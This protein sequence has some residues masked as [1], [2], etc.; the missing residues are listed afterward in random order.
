MKH[1]KLYE[2]FR[3]YIDF[4]SFS[5]NDIKIFDIIATKIG[6]KLGYSYVKNLNHGSYGCFY[7]L[8]DVGLKITYDKYEATIAKIQKE[9]NYKE[10]IPV[11]DVFKINIINN[12]YEKQ[13]YGIVEK[14]AN[15][16]LMSCEEKYY[17]NVCC[18]VMLDN[19][20]NLSY[21]EIKQKINK[22]NGDDE[23]ILYNVYLLYDFFVRLK[24]LSDKIGIKDLD[25][26][27]HTSNIMKNDGDFVLVDLGHK[28]NIQEIE[29]EITIKL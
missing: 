28:I 22:F 25:I 14:M 15:S 8:K 20:Y 21:D 12:P 13:L 17:D 18:Y 10:I 11:I 3:K 4:Y 24:K 19:E 9:N 16:S 2:E 5:G 6:R 7:R 1:L 26:L 23:R 29:K 27:E